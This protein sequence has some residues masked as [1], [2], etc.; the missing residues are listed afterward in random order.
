MKRRSTFTLFL[1]PIAVTSLCVASSARST[2]PASVAEVPFELVNGRIHVPVFVDGEGPFDFLFDN[3]ASGMG[4]LDD[5]VRVALGIPVVRQADNFDGVNT[6]QINVVEVESLALGPLVHRDVELL[7]R[8]YSM[9]GVL[10]AEYFENRLVTVDYPARMLRVVEGALDPMDPHVV[11]YDSYFELPIRI[12][13]GLRV[14]SLDTGSTLTMHLPLS[15]ADSVQTTELVEAGRA[16]R[17]NTEFSLYRATLLEPVV[18]AGNTLTD[19][20]VVFSERATWINIGSAL[21]HEFA[22]TFDQANRRIR[23]AR[24]ENPE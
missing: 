12:G 23:I 9:D 22:V 2:P 16:R 11:A 7:S 19:L 5:S 4:R 18:L 17:A 14:G 15:Y 13:S 24:P 8:D 1:A 20:E 6:S 10:G 3:G 21:L